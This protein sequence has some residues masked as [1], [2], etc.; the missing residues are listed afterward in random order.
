[1]A[2]L[3]HAR[4]Y[5]P[6]LNDAGM[7]ALPSFRKKL[8]VP[9]SRRTIRCSV[10][11]LLFCCLATIFW[12]S[13]FL[14]NKSLCFYDTQLT[15]NVGLTPDIH[16]FF[17]FFY[18]FKVFPVGAIPEGRT[19]ANIWHVDPLTTPPFLPVNRVGADRYLREHGNRLIMDFSQPATAIRSGDFSKLFLFLPHAWLTGSPLNPTVK[20]FNA[21]LFNVT[22]LAVLVSFWAEGYLLLGILIVLLVGSSPFQLVEVYRNDN[23]NG[24]AICGVLIGLA[25]HLRYMSGRATVDC[26]AWVTAIAMGIFGALLLNVRSEAGV[27]MLA[28]PF[29][30]LLIPKTPWH[31]RVALAVILV[32]SC[33]CTER[34]L[35]SF[36]KYQFE[37]A[38]VFV[39]EHGGHP[40][41]GPYSLHHTVWHPIFIGLG[42]YGYQRGYCWDDRKAFSYAISK[43]RDENHHAYTYNPSLYYLNDTY[44]PEGWYRVYPV[45]LPGYDRILRQKVLEDIRNDPGWYM[46]V[47][48]QRLVHILNTTSR[49]SLSAGYGWNAMRFSG[50]WT[51]PTLLMLLL[52]RKWFLAGV[53]AF[54]LPLSATAFFIYSG[55]GTALYNIFHLMTF[56]VWMFLLGRAALDPAG[57]LF[58]RQWARRVREAFVVSGPRVGMCH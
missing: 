46:N 48:Y 56:A 53:I 24:L 5:A 25:L 50:W 11:R 49:L 54:T 58:W 35:K 32:G 6:L 37:R 42:D 55:R 13:H 38:I 41:A 1:M 47:L 3:K 31:K 16:Q 18:Y 23:V 29:V 33:S 43:L 27:V 17:Y 10:I 21:I 20:P 28:C 45:D 14:S 8:I 40:Y 34:V 7:T 12:Q 4:Y 30:W 44:D 51:L 57:P 9:P 15:A 26:W 39:R 36:W 52:W 19:P 22:L 2:S